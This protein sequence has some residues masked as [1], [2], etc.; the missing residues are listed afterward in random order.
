MPFPLLRLDI[1]VL[2]EAQP[3]VPVREL[4]SC[5]VAGRFLEVSQVESVARRQVLRLV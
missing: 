4:L 3:S 1:L 5:R 2:L